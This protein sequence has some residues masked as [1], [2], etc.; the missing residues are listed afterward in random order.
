MK[1]VVKMCVV[2]N[3]RSV[4]SRGRLDEHV[5]PSFKR[6]GSRT[7]HRVASLTGR[8]RWVARCFRPAVDKQPTVAEFGRCRVD[9]CC[10]S[11]DESV[12]MSSVCCLCATTSDFHLAPSCVNRRE[13]ASAGQPFVFALLKALVKP[14][15]LSV[16][17]VP[18]DDS[19]IHLIDLDL[20]PLKKGR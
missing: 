11:V 1:I 3:I 15:Q 14:I 8:W 6:I 13:F 17:C 5:T 10:R 7:E 4:S 16:S 19:L 9:G 12:R 2:V 18:S 20:L